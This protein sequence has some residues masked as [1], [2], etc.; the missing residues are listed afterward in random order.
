[1]KTSIEESLWGRF[2]LAVDK[3]SGIS[4]LR[5]RL[6]LGAEGVDDGDVSK[7]NPLPMYEPPVSPTDRSGMIAT[8]GTAQQ[9]LASNASRRGCWLKNVSTL[10]IWVC[11]VGTA[12]ADSPSE[13]VK[14]GQYWFPAEGGVTSGAISILGA[15]TGQKFVGREW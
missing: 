6:A 5:L 3:I 1:M 12:T 13:E 14:P 4:F 9:W 2:K 15:T 8:G 7:T 10:S 11:D